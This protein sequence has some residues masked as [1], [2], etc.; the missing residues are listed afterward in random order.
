MRLVSI[1]FIMCC[2]SIQAQES[3]KKKKDLPFNITIA[4][5]PDNV[6]TRS[7]PA[8]FITTFPEN[9]TIPNSFAINGYIGLSRE[10]NNFEFMA[11]AELHRNT[12]ISSK[13]FTQQY[14]IVGKYYTNFNLFSIPWIITPE[15][16]IKYSEDKIND[17]KGMQVLGY[18][19]IEY[20]LASG[21]KFLNLLEPGGIFPGESSNVSKWIQIKHTNSFGLEFINYED[22]LLFNASFS[23]ELYP[24]S[25]L[26]K[27][28]F[29]QFNILQLRYSIVERAKLNDQETDVF[30]GTFRSFAANL[31]YKVDPKGNTALSLGYEYNTGGNPLKGL[32]DTSFGQLKLSIKANFN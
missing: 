21:N 27:K 7:L 25:G 13:Q 4:N 15:V 11:T 5:A 6:Y 1:L 16:S 24:L 23:L 29:G 22:I 30:V 19:P 20:D 32:A 17:K 2:L 10:F 9:D 8:T 18:I 26:L 14:G 3:E 31:Q 28:Q 12:L